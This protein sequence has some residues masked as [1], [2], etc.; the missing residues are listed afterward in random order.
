MIVRRGC[1]LMIVVAL[2]AGLAVGF[3]VEAR[4]QKKDAPAKKDPPE[5][6]PKPKQPAY[7]TV[8]TAGPD[9][10]VQGEYFG[11][12]A[13]NR[14]KKLGIQVIALGNGTFRACFLKGGLPGAGWDGKSKIEIDGKTDGDKTVF[15]GKGYEAVIK[16]ERLQ[17]RDAK[18]QRLIGERIVRKS[19][20]LGAKPPA[21][22]IVLFDGSSADEWAKGHMDKRKLLAAGS[23]SKRTFTD[24]TLHVEFITPFKP[25]GRGQGRGNS[26]VYLQHRYE[27]Q[28][29]D[30]F[31]LAGM[32]NECGGIYKKGRPKVNMCLPPLTWQTYDIEFTAP[33]FE[34]GKKV[35]PACA[36]VRHNGVVIHDKLKID[37]KTGGSK[38][39][40]GEPGAIFLQGHGNPVFYRNIWIVEKK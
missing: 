15:E 3:A 8:E 19:P 26:G 17:A 40:E 18:G 21:G 39:N 11:Q 31:G 10:K 29:L 37:G 12:V 5:K 34:D 33:A 38:G 32:D 25:L 6:K 28:V 9:Y 7:L 2:A 24:F 1:R 35:A 13:G 23:A 20:T 22:A 14:D 27:I 30:S 4:A 16:N 36:T